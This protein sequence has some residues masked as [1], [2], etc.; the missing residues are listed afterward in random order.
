MFSYDERLL[1]EKYIGECVID[2]SIIPQG[3]HRRRDEL[4]LFEGF[5]IPLTRRGAPD[6]SLGSVRVNITVNCCHRSCDGRTCNYEEE[7]SS[8]SHTP[9]CLSCPV[10]N[11]TSI[12]V[13]RVQDPPPPDLPVGDLHRS[14]ECPILKCGIP[15]TECPHLL[16]PRMHRN[17]SVNSLNRRGSSIARL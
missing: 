17:S 8:V 3:F 14:E 7:L 11:I 4:F 12:P 13:F 1:G 15:I 6:S 9:K 5:L 10:L 2:C 16:V